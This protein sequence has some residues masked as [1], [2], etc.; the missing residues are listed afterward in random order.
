MVERFGAVIGT[1]ASR[2]ARHEP[3][4][5][6]GSAVKVG[7]DRLLRSLLRDR[8]NTFRWGTINHC[9]GIAEQAACLEGLPPDAA[10]QGMLPNWCPLPAATP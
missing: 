2:F 4:T 1:I 6:H 9:L 10:G 8:S 3:L 5:E 7:D